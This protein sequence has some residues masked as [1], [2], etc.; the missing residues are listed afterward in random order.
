VPWLELLESEAEGRPREAVASSRHRFAIL[1]MVT[2]LA[3]C[4]AAVAATM[5]LPPTIATGFCFV[6]F[7]GQVAKA[8]L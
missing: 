3:A 1:T 4:G 8:K 2:P 7:A 5:A 6:A